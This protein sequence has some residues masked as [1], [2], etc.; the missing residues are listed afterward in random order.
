M[1][2]LI[3]DSSKINRIAMARMLW[4]LPIYLVLAVIEGLGGLAWLA[5]GALANWVNEPYT[6]SDQA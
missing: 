4:A 6:W 3:M 2:G 1:A 5:M